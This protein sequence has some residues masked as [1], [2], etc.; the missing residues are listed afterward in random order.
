MSE[1]QWY[2]DT[3]R[4]FPHCWGK[5]VN[6]TRPKHKIFSISPTNEKKITF[7]LIITILLR[8]QPKLFVVSEIYGNY[9]LFS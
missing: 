7:Q 4:D 1:A 2:T 8:T 5:R 9:P 6:S 3:S